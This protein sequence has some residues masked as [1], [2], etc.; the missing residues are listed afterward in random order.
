MPR[1]PASR[2]TASAGRV[3]DVPARVVL[4]VVLAGALLYRLWLLG[5]DFPINDGALFLRFVDEIA[6]VFPALP[7]SVP[8]NGQS[9]PFAYPPLAFWLAAALANA[10]ADTIEIL[11]VAPILA[12]IVTVG[13]FSWLLHRLG[14]QP[15][16]VAIATF[17]LVTNQRAWEWLVMGGGLSRSLGALLTMAALIPL[18]RQ[19][20]ARV[21]TLALLAS[22]AAVAGAVL[23]HPHWGIAAATLT[24]ALLATRAGNVRVFVAQAL[25]VGLTALLL[26]SP[27][28]FHVFSV[29]GPGPV[30][31]AG[32][33]SYQ[34]NLVGTMLVNFLK[35]LVANPFILLG[36]FVLLTRRDW[37]PFAALAI[38]IFITPRLSP[39]AWAIPIAIL[40][41]Q[42][43]LFAVGYLRRF[44]IIRRGALPLVAL[45]VLSIVAARAYR[46]A[47]LASD[48]F[49][50]LD[51]DLRAGMA[52]V[53]ANHPGRRFVILSSSPWYFDASAEWF[54]VLA[55]ATS[56]NTAQG[57]EWLPNR[58][59]AQ[60]VEMN[61]RE[62]SANC[63]E[64]PAALRAYGRAD[65]IWAE[66]HRECFR[67]ADAR[68]VFAN[69]DVAIYPAVDWSLVTGTGTTPEDR[70]PGRHD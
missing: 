40:A 7:A 69:E 41:G 56:L 31:A 45:A 18:A 39:Q 36:G 20:G 2:S 11:R 67:A 63:R 65:Y 16:L 42:G 1:H 61:E 58:Q 34:Q 35:T 64:L 49:R 60:L 62:K 44:H 48:Q 9:I 53:A 4:A 66:T 21:S 24:L 57:R 27:W 54:P 52:W 51:P 50:P 22:A 33:T 47:R 13:L 12:N 3:G 38:A 25:A 68:P 5:N 23:S 37:F 30:L 17:F 15:W 19:D 70:S 55:N 8:Y 32:T 14:Y 28:I 43:V 59:F 6:S 29:H 46:D 26:A 10:G